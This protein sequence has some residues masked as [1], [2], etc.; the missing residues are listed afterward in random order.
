MKL[1]VHIERVRVRGGE[2]GHA[3]GA[4]LERAL[5]ERLRELFMERGLSELP[6]RSLCVPRLR[7]PARSVVGTLDAGSVGQGVAGA[8]HGEVTGG[9]SR[10]G[11]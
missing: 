2:L 1:H 4:A 10:G 9:Q 7:V 8:L 11:E 5:R 6:E 3:D